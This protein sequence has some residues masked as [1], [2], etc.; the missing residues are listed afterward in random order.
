MDGAEKYRTYAWRYA[1]ADLKFC[2]RCGSCVASEDLHI[3]DQAQLIC[4]TCKFIFYLDPKLVVTAVVASPV[5]ILLLKRAEAPSLGK[6]G[7]PGGYVSRGE[8]I[9]AAVLNEVREEAG[10]QHVSL[11][12]L[13]A[14]TP[15]SD[16][17][18]IQLIFSA[19][20]DQT[21]P[22]PNLESLEARF[23]PRTEIP[24]PEL[25]FPS[26]RMAV[27]LFLQGTRA[28]GLVGC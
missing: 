1:R 13:L 7:L 22:A 15:L 19:Y 20:T 10:L 26:T 28:V 17:Q 6:W 14:F 23:F 16:S 21:F 24:W 3:A 18:G 5:G 9:D 27:E 11:D 25:A 2:P 12:G 8:D 4:D